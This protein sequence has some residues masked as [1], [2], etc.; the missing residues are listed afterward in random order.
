MREAPCSSRS[1]R[2]ATSSQAEATSLES[3][4]LLDIMPS[5][6]VVF[7]RRQPC[8]VARDGRDVD[9]IDAPFPARGKG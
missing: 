9:G 8:G 3:D 1:S 7:G 2:A 4:L 5:G 6:A